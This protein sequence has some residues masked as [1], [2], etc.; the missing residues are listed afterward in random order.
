[1]AKNK[2]FEILNNFASGQC[3][4]L[5][6][7]FTEVDIPFYTLLN[8]SQDKK[9]V[10]NDY[11]QNNKILGSENEESSLN[12]SYFVSKIIEKGLEIL[13]IKVFNKM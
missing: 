7:K 10:Y 1:M 9:K 11:Y 8:E 4:M 12:I 6:P 3:I 2:H 5:R 13:D